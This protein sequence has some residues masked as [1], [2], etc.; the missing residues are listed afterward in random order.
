MCSKN[1]NARIDGEPHY[2]SRLA[3]A[4]NAVN[5]LNQIAKRQRLLVID[6]HD[7]HLSFA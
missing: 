5:A 4:A 7:S 1:N 3:M 2:G 6:F